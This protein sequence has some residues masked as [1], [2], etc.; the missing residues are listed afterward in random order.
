MKKNKNKTTEPDLNGAGAAVDGWGEPVDR[1]I[2]VNQHVDIERNIELT[3]VTVDGG[4]KTNMT[5]YL[6][7]FR[8]P[9]IFH[10]LP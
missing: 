2:A 5:L 4:E 7:S 6:I 10:C 8:Q 9:L 3:I 1:T